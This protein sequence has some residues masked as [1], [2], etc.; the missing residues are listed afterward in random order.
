VKRVAVVV[1]ENG[2][3]EKSEAAKLINFSSAKATRSGTVTS[4][5]RYSEDNPL[6]PVAPSLTG[7][8][9]A[10]VL[11]QFVRGQVH[12]DAKAETNKDRLRNQFDSLLDT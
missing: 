10:Q 1:G 11:V 2:C 9:Q 6:P 12:V 3:S 8:S 4:Q 5:V 7:W